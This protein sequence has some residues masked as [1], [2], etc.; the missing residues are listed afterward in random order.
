[1]DASSEALGTLLEALTRDFE[2]KIWRSK[3]EAK[4]TTKKVP[5]GKNGKFTTPPGAAP[6][7]AIF[8]L[9][10]FKIAKMSIFE[11]FQDDIPIQTVFGTVF[12]RFL[13]LVEKPKMSKSVGGFAYF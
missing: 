13:R 2:A 1:M 11:G 6:G 7:A 10:F 5:P 3:L 9:K 8:G 12:G 4:K